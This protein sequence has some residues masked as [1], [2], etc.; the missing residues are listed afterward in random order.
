MSVKRRVLVSDYVLCAARAVE[1]N[2]QEARLHE[3]EL[4]HALDNLNELHRDTVL[5]H[6]NGQLVPH[7]SGPS[8]ALDEITN[9]L[10]PLHFAGVARA[11]SSAFDCLSAP[12]YFVFA[13]PVDL[14]RSDWAARKTEELK[15][16]TLP[17]QLATLRDAVVAIIADNAPW[18]EWLNDY[19]N[20]VVHRGRRLE[21]RTFTP[22]VSMILKENETPFVHTTVVSGLPRD[23][24]LSDMEAFRAFRGR[25]I[26]LDEPVHLLAPELVSRGNKML[27]DIAQVLNEACTIRQ[28]NAD[29]VAL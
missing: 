29:L 26:T 3:L 5:A 22:N 10:V 2:L 8:C 27:E 17:T 6:P 19:R 20:M 25:S 14:R 18:F 13:T 4:A 21:M 7:L 11:L 24:D 16:Q 1:Q 23:P 15:K 12:T 28:A 9:E